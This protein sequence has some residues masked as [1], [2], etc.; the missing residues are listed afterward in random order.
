MDDTQ[1]E[2]LLDPQIAEI[3]RTIQQA[4]EELEQKLRE[5]THQ[6]HLI[7]KA[8][9]ERARQHAIQQARLHIQS[10]S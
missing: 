8:V 2:A 9:R 1:S 5:C 10:L 6:Q 7:L 4:Q 3:K